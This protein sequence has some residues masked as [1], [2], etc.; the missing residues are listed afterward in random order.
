MVASRA[1]RRALQASQPAP[2]PVEAWSE[3]EPAS[4]LVDEVLCSSRLDASAAAIWVIWPNLREVAERF[5]THIGRTFPG[6][7]RESL[8]DRGIRDA[9]KA[10]LAATKRGEPVHRGASAF[11]SVIADCGRALAETQV[12]ALVAGGDLT[13]WEP[14]DHS[15]KAWLEKSGALG[16]YTREIPSVDELDAWCASVYLASRVMKVH[17][18]RLC[19]EALARPGR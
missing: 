16:L 19:A 9:V 7:G 3:R 12:S 14:F 2:D 17:D 18:F 4:R 10:Y 11:L 6:P 5:A 15:F 1:A 13:R 8:V